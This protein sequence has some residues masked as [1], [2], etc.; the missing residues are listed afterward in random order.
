L[1]IWW[2]F[3]YPDIGVLGILLTSAHGFSPGKWQAADAVLSSLNLATVT[4]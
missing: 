3:S 2:T 4:E 1:N